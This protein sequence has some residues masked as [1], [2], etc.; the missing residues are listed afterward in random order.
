MDLEKHVQNMMSARLRL[1]DVLYGYVDTSLMIK[2]HRR[3][4][5]FQTSIKMK[6]SFRN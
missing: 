6:E 3:W 5:I 2:W 1:L 4:R